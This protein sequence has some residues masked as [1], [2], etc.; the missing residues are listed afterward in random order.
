MAAM[1]QTAFPSCK[2]IIVFWFKFHEWY[3]LPGVQLAKYI[4]GT[5]NARQQAGNKPLFIGDCMVYWRI[6]ASPCLHDIKTMTET[7]LRRYI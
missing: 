4:T 3:L 6:Y 5:D 1:L 7:Y 2:K